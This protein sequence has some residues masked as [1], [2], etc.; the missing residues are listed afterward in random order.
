MTRKAAGWTITELTRKSLCW[1]TTTRTTEAE[2]A[3]TTMTAGWTTCGFTDVRCLPMT[4]GSCTVVG[5]RAEVPYEEPFDDD[6]NDGVIGWS[7]RE[8]AGVISNER[9][10][11]VLGHTTRLR[12]TTPRNLIDHG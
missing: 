9:H 1:G 3:V 7:G 8:G 10:G 6:H 4:C 11:H 2:R 5:L 12:Q